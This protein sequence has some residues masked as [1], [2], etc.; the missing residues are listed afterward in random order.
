MTDIRVDVGYLAELA[1]R[2][3]Q[4][5]V[6]LGGVGSATSQLQD[7]HR[8]GDSLE[9][10]ERRW[11][12]AREEFEQALI[13]MREAFRAISDSFANLDRGLAASVDLDGS[14]TVLSSHG[15]VD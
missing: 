8:V 11:S 5:S 1:A 7:V 9:R 14:G 3:Q 12:Q 2:C 6:Q 15:E 10:F 13:E 4:V